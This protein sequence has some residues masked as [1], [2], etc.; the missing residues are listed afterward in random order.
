MYHDI[1]AWAQ[2]LLGV[3]CFVQVIKRYNIGNVYIFHLYYNLIST[4]S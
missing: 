3:E 1:P 4:L 2:N